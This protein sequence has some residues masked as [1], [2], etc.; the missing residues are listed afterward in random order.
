[1]KLLSWPAIRNFGDMPNVSIWEHFLRLLSDRA[2][3]E[4]RQRALLDKI[5]AFRQDISAR[6]SRMATS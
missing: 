1:M 6:P 4:Q 3:L 2:L 5:E